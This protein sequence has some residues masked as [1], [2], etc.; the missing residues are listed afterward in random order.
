MKITKLLSTLTASVVVLG[1]CACNSAPAES[2]TQTADA[3]S[4]SS[5]I[6]AMGN[7]PQTLDP[8]QGWGHGNAPLLQSTLIAYNAQME[9]KNDLAT[10][11]TLSDDRLT[12]TF[13]LREDAFF[14]DGEQVTANDVAFTFETAKAAQGAVD[15]TFME[16]AVAQDAFTV[17]ITLSSPTSFFLNTIASV[18]IVPQHA[19]SEA[20]GTNPAVTSGP[21]SF[22]EWQPQEQ[23]ILKAN[24]NYYG[25]KPA[26]ENVTLV[27]MDEDAALAAVKA[28][29]V[30]VAVTS[31]TLATNT[32][33]GYHIEQV[34]AA[35]NR[36]FT[37]PMQ[38]ANSGTTETGQPYG[39]DVTCH[40]EIRQAIAYA[41]DREQIA[42]VALNGYAT[43]AYSENDGMPW[44][45]PDGKIETDV[46]YAKKLLADAGW[47]DT[48]GDGIVEKDGL[49]AE[50]TC[51]YPSGDSARQAITL[52]AAEQVKAIGINIIPEGLSW[53]EI[54]Q[55][56][57]SNAVT[58]GWG[59][60]TPSE[61]YYL[62]NS[63]GRFREDCYNVEGYAS[64]ITDTYLTAAMEAATI[65][66]AYANFQKVQW[67][68]KT[69]TAMQGECP[70][71]WIV[72][73]DHL[74][75]VRDGLSI[76]EQPVHPHGQD[77][78]LIQNLSDW[79]WVQ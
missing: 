14:S 74:Y 63:A 17:V 75:Y 65:E 3:G 49:Q 55:R 50:F 27:F 73:L 9:L 71:V 79:A 68:G 19:Y 7:E 28:G 15:L 11:Y 57:Y 2:S 22:V 1:L 32:I 72:N 10:G 42:D 34:T 13:T 45:N 59:A 21:Y 29:Q 53:D 30:D 44:N 54:Y 16:S 33:V 37:L 5:V 31:A 35:D 61:T 56:M 23:L 78:P 41:I 67:D 76:G 58:M 20:Y 70:W 52:A 18:G 4:K 40:P 43:P 25:D 60:A 36:G 39:N 46:E 66:E 69:G 48:D 51:M 24:D 26:I 77:L 38:P 64:E 12:Y 8:T 6:V 47:A 62:Y